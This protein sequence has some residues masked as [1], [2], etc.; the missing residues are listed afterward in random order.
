MFAQSPRLKVGTGLSPPVLGG[1][2]R[3]CVGQRPGAQV[4]GK[5]IKSYISVSGGPARA[6]GS[7]RGQEEREGRFHEGLLVQTLGGCRVTHSDD[8]CRP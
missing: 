6:L 5:D 1:R 4:G 7:R 8:R 2:P 3:C